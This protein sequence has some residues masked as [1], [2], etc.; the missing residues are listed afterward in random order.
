MRKVVLFSNIFPFYSK[1]F[2]SLL[3]EKIDNLRIGIQFY[4]NRGI[5]L[6]D[7]KK[8]YSKKN[9]EKFFKVK[10]ILFKNKHLIYQFGVIYRS[11]FWNIEKGIF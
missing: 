8:T 7:I 11:I 10:N 5:K 9:Q 1:A 2:W 3:V 6:V 4:D